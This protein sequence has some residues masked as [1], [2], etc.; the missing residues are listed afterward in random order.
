MTLR[1]VH[2]FCQFVRINQKFG[3]INEGNKIL[4]EGV[5]KMNEGDS[6][7]E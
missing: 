3:K 5:G 6:S 4:N 7:T 2:F 1:V